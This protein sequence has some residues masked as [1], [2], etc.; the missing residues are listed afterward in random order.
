VYKEATGKQLVIDG[1]QRLRTIWGYFDGVLPDGNPF[2]LRGVDPQWNG[3]LYNE[4]KEADKMRFR[5]SILRVVIVEQVD[6]NDITSIYHIFER[7]NTGGTRLTTQEVRNCGYHGTF[8]DMLFEIN[9]YDKWRHIFGTTKAD[10]RL[11]DI[12]LITRFFAL[13]EMKY[14]KP[15]K[16]FL[17]TFMGKHQWDSKI[18]G[19]KTLFTGTVDRV[20]K[21]LG[22]KPFNVKRGINAAVFDSVMVAFAKNTKIPK[23]VGQRYKKLLANKSYDDAIKAH[24]TDVDTVKQRLELAEEVLFH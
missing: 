15:M 22:T 18:E 21:A 13:N 7:L 4:L 24:T 12:E 19:Y 16:E 9:G 3:L 10:A 23:D 11:R 5:D 2:Y 20:Y 1:Q 14:S 6:P 17:N 8:N